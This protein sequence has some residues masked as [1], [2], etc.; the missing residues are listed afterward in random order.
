MGM[1]FQHSQR[2]STQSVGQH[3]SNELTAADEEP[4]GNNV[5]TA[6]DRLAGDVAGKAVRMAA[7]G[8]GLGIL[9]VEGQA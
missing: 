8:G 3:G 5:S 4:A 6:E 7:A 1:N 2:L 9:R